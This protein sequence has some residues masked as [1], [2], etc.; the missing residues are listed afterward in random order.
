M[1]P[2]TAFN[3]LV[4]SKSLVVARFSEVSGLQ[5]ETET[6]EYHEGGRNNF[7]HK[8]PKVTKYQN[9]V[10]KR[11]ITNST[12]L[13][14]WHQDV[15]AGTI[16]RENVSVILLDSTGGEKKRWNFAG[17]YPVK[18]MGPDLKGDSNT[19]AIETL[20]LTHNGLFKA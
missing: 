17:A 20:E 19:V 8:L 12:E 1:V 2:Y 13:W 5:A 11:G 10:L 3:F 6:E 15:I 7:V 18:W 9:L 14:Q 4:E 16:Q